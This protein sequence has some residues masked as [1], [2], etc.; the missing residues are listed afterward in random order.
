[1]HRA[2]QTMRAF[3]PFFPLLS[4]LEAFFKVCVSTHNDFSRELVQSILDVFDCAMNHRLWSLPKRWTTNRRCQLKQAFSRYVTALYGAVPANVCV[5]QTHDDK[6]S[7]TMRWLG[8]AANRDGSWCMTSSIG[9]NTPF[10]RA[11]CR[12]ECAVWFPNFWSESFFDS[13]NIKVG[14]EMH[15][16]VGMPLESRTPHGLFCT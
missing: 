5:L 10:L 14:F 6:D 16:H 13:R 15:F 9:H 8:R 2:Y 12:P 11:V 4:L 1:M 7:H 3:Y